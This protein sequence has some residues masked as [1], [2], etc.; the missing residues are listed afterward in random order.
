MVFNPCDGK[1]WSHPVFVNASAELRVFLMN[2]LSPSADAPKGYTLSVEVSK[3]E[4]T[5]TKTSKGETAFKFDI[6]D[7]S[8]FVKRIWTTRRVKGSLNEDRKASLAS[9]ADEL[10]LA[11]DWSLAKAPSESVSVDSTDIF[12]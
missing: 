1:G 4:L 8:A 10:G 3:S 11:I 9:L 2:A 12:G 5:R 6:S 7:D